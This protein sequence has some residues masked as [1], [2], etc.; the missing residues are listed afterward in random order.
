MILLGLVFSPPTRSK[1]EYYLLLC[2]SLLGLMLLVRTLHLLMLFIALEI[3]SVCSYGLVFFASEKKATEAGA[4]YIFFGIFS[5]ALM[6]YGISLYWSINGTFI[7]T[8]NQFPSWSDD[9]IFLLISAGL[10]FKTSAAPF[11]I[12][13][14][15]VIESAPLPIA[16]FFTV[17]PKAGALAALV[18][19]LP[20]QWKLLTLIAIAS[21]VIGSLSAIG[22]TNARR[23][24]A[25]AAIAQVGFLLMPVLTLSYGAL[26]YYLWVYLFLNAL[27]FAAIAWIENKTGSQQLSYFAGWGANCPL[28][29]IAMTTAMAGL[30]GLPPTAGFAA[31]L[32]VFLSLWQYS[33]NYLLLTLFFVGI[34]ATIISV[35]FY[36][37]APYEMF[38]KKAASAKEKSSM[39]L[40]Q[41][42][43]LIG[44]T[45]TIFLLIA[46]S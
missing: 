34:V 1:I 36:L 38:F 45:G 3:T 13:T 30:I 46:F 11:H 40:L 17:V 26:I 7:L 27:A 44:M 16:A 33:S 23:L 6:L 24:M 28:L 10:L 37:K 19:L 25:Y 31:K 43:W 20:N 32:L 5:S 39:A 41:R 18:N 12:W 9:L 14:P 35:Y 22:Q 21:L 42:F 15:D 2:G 8:K 4:K 29:G